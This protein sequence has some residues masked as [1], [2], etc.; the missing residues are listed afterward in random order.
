MSSTQTKTP[1]GR[2]AGKARGKQQQNQGHAGNRYQG[3]G[4]V[5]EGGL[6]YA[7]GNMQGN[8]VN[9]AHMH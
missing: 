6:L 2:S 8:V 4:L 9:P 7:T 5:T 3:G 1:A